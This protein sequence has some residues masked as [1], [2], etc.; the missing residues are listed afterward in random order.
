VVKLATTKTFRTFVLHYHYDAVQG[1]LTDLSNGAV[2]TAQDGF[3]TTAEG[4]ILLP[5]YRT[6][7]GW[8]NYGRLW[9][10]P[11]IRGP[12]M[13]VFVWTFVFAAASVLTTFLLGLLLAIVLNEE[14]LALRSFYRTL[15]ILPWAIPAFISL[16]VWRGLLN[17]DAGPINALLSSVF[18]GSVPWFNNPWWAKV[19]VLLINLWLGFP[20]MMTICLGA[21][22]GIPSELYEAA[23]VDGAT[24]WKQFVHITQPLI[25][26]AVGPLL[27]GSFAFNFNNFNVIFLL[28]HGGPPIPGAQTPA[29]ATDILISYTYR[30]A[31]EGGWGNQYGFAAAITM[32]IFLIVGTISA[33]NFKFTGALEEVSKNV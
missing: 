29:G 4:T 21:L 14:G 20:Y 22:Q 6:L 13:R 32:V 3:F 31:F 2:Y 16:M 23:Y 24:R 11:R 17:P 9:N 30:L 1:R 28:T 26:V 15:L 5:G 12:F 18:G 8:R 27:V 10:N 7:V 19:A 25:L 33:L